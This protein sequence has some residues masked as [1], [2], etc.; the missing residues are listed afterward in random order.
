MTLAPES[1]YAAYASWRDIA[2][3]GPI[4]VSVVI[5]AYNEQARIVPTIGAFAAHLART[6]LTW[7]LKI[8]RAH[9]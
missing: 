2:Q 8:G 9:V 3:T 4:D 5:P 1:R 6:G 7:E